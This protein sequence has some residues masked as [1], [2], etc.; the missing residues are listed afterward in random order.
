MYC[1]IANTGDILH[2]CCPVS[3]NTINEYAM[4]FSYR[5][6]TLKGSIFAMS[7]QYVN[8][9]CIVFLSLF[10]AIRMHANVHNWNLF[11]ICLVPNMHCRMVSVSQLR[12]MQIN[13][14]AFLF[15]N[16]CG[17]KSKYVSS[18]VILG[19]TNTI[20]K[21]PHLCSNRWMEKVGVLCA[22]PHGRQNQ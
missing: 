20:A 11:N 12:A 3:E 7:L 1:T 18:V 22:W 21:A 5:P 9:V 4:Q 15:K 17:R 14:F 2:N 6:L 19:V 8:A 13:Y 10:A 16:V